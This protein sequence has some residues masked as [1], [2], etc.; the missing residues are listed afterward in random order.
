MKT[1]KARPKNTGY[2]S[3]PLR[4]DRDSLTL[5]P[6]HEE[7]RHQVQKKINIKARLKT[8]PK[9]YQDKII[10][11]DFFGLPGGGAKNLLDNIPQSGIASVIRLSRLATI[12]NGTPFSGRTPRGIESSL[13]SKK[14]FKRS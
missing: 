6:S 13:I 7:G 9:S 11:D 8:T 2:P 10:G 5:I 12:F 1:I 14:F 3:R 4:N